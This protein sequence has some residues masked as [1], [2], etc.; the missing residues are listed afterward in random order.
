MRGDLEEFLSLAMRHWNFVAQALASADGIFLPWFEAEEGEEI[1]R[2]NRW[3]K[4]FLRGINLCREG[5]NEIFEDKEK[6]AVLLPV[7][8]L[9]HE[10][11]PDPELR[12]WEAPPD[13]ELRKQVL[14]GLSVAAPWFY[15]YFSGH[16]TRE[17]RPEQTGAREQRIK[18]G[19]NDPCYCGSGKKYKRCC[20]NVTIH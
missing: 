7:L 6:F 4:G 2:G 20:G 8:A 1:P 10:N 19:R 3:A 13:P 14:A 12:S 17:P 9:V 5:W 16:R 15:N 11:D 18:I